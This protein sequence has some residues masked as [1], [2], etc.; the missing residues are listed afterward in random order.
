VFTGSTLVNLNATTITLPSG[1]LTAGLAVGDSI[2]FYT[3]TRSRIYRVEQVNGTVITINLPFNLP[4]AT[5]SF[6]AFREKL[7]TKNLLSD[8]LTYPFSVSFV[9]GNPWAVMIGNIAEL[10]AKKQDVLIPG[11]YPTF[12]ILD[13]D[14]TIN[15]IYLS[16]TPSFTDT[17]LCQVVRP[18]YSTT[19]PI[20]VDA[21]STSDEV[22]AEIVPVMSTAVCTSGSSTVTF[23][24]GTN[25]ATWNILPGDFFKLYTG[26]D[27]NVDIGY[28]NGVFVVAEC[29]ASQII[30]TRPLIMTQNTATYTFKRTVIY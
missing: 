3:T 18:F 28:G 5:Y 13:F 25:L 20:D 23:S 1:N 22:E 27:A 15:A 8:G 12:D 26:T 10:I 2:F 30:L 21:I 7:L 24:G 6:C 11:F 19:F 16:P 29:T 9:S 4:T 14:E 17:D